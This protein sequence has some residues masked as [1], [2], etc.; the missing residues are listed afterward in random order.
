[1]KL[2][3]LGKVCMVFYIAISSGLQPFWTRDPLFKP[4]FFATHVSSVKNLKLL[5]FN[6]Y[7]KKKSY[8]DSIVKLTHRLKT[9][10]I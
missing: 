4:T 9:T 5:K 6:F 3:K 1:M 8:C 10:D 2:G 7:F